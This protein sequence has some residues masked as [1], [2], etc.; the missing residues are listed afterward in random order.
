MTEIIDKKTQ[1]AINKIL[2]KEDRVELIRVK[3]GV[4]VIHIKRKEVKI[5]K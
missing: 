4:K 1:E 2:E 3:D 5:T